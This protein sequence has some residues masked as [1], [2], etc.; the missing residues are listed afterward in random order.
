M[1]EDPENAVWTRKI[2]E[3]L[4]AAGY[5][6]ARISSLSTF[7]KVVGGLAWCISSVVTDLQLDC[8]VVFQENAS[9]GAKM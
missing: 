4:L 6:R 7:D 8:D 2:L 5:F 9:I 3:T 1:E